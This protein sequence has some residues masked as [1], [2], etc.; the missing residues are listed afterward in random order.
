[1]KNFLKI[2]L[3]IIG[4]ILVGVIVFVFFISYTANYKKTTCDTSVS[5]DGKYELTLQAVGE[6]DWPFGSASGRLVLMEGKDKISQTDFELHN[7]GGSITSNCWKV[8]WYED[9]LEV[10]LS[11]EEQF[12]EQ[13]ILY[14]DGT[15]EIQQLTDIA[16]IAVDYP[17]GEK[18]DESRVITEQSFEVDL[19]DWGEVRFVSYLP[20]YD[21][22]WED[23]SFVLAKDNQIVYYFPAYFENNS[24]END[25]VGMFD[26]VEAVGFQDI[27]GVTYSF[28]GNGYI[29]TGW[30]EKGVKDYYFNEDGSYDPSKVRPMLALTFDDGPGEDTDELLDCLEQN[31]AHATFFMLGQNV[32]SYPDAPKRML[33]LGCEIGSHSWDHT[34]LTTIDLDAVAKQ[35]SDTDD[36]LIQA[37]GQ[38]A[39]VARAPYGDGNSDIYNT[40]NKPFFM[41]SLDT[42]DWKL[43]DADADYSAVMN[44]DLTDGT[45]ILMHDIHEPSVKAALR[46]IPDLIAQGY[47]LVTVSEMAEAKN[48]TLQNACYVDFWPSTLSNGGVPGYQG[49]S[50]ASASTDGT[51]GTSDASADSSDGSTDSSDGSGDYSDGSSDDGSYDDGSSDDGSYDDGSSDDS[52]DYSDDSV[53]YGDGTE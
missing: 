10:I 38:A 21:T 13:V 6:P 41:W 2:M 24:T 30:V 29:Q 20:T 44:G 9:Y 35:F 37:C 23:V 25:S 40:V 52:E 28:D 33:E 34:Q 36:A 3:C 47:K 53:D 12:D 5:P 32:S 49:G 48:V 4:S 45:I 26:S 7:D 18:L 50:D 42:E 27:D 1:M 22:L 14:F 39:S 8:T 17:S 43:L 15:K 19:N 11:G 16:D 31:N 51:D 46:L